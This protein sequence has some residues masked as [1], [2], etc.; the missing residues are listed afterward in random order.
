MSKSTLSYDTLYHLLRPLSKPDLIR[1]L[2][3]LAQE[4]LENQDFLLEALGVENDPAGL[5]LESA[6]NELD[7]EIFR[8]KTQD[9]SYIGEDLE[10]YEIEEILDEQFLD[11]LQEVLWEKGNRL[12]ETGAKQELADLMIL[13]LENLY[14]WPFTKEERANARRLMDTALAKVFVKAGFSRQQMISIAKEIGKWE[15]MR[16]KGLALED[17]Q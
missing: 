9:F 16:I 11:L 14:V 3:A 2:I 7:R 12:I 5:I 8:M 13:C 1:L 6:E 10:D 15:E 17:S 4:R